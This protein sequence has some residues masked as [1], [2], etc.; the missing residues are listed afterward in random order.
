MDHT[1]IY[2]YFTGTQTIQPVPMKDI[3]VQKKDEITRCLN[4]TDNIDKLASTDY[5]K[6]HSTQICTDINYTNVNANE[7]ILPLSVFN[8][9]KYE[10]DTNVTDV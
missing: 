9:S 3:Q 7:L 10:H 6:G 1:D 2:R 4:L 5:I 8:G